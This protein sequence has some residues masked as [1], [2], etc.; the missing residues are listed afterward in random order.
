MNEQ[1]VSVIMPAYNSANFITEAIASVQ[2]Q[3]YKNW[4]LFVIDDF[5]TD[6]T[7]SIVENIIKLEPRVQL[8]KNLKNE[9]AGATRNKGITAAKG[10]FIA[11]LDAD[12]L[13]LPQKLE[14]QIKFM[15][16]DQLAMSFSSY[17][18]ISE[19][20]A[21]LSKSIVAP[22]KLSYKKLL[23]A[24][25]VG[26]LTGMYDVSKTGKIY[27]PLLRKRQDWALWL[28][29]LKK[30]K[31]GKGIQQP[32]ACY[33]IRK[34]GISTNKWAL[35]KYNYQIYNRFLDFG[36]LKSSGYMMLFLWEHFFVKTKQK[37]TIKT[38]GQSHEE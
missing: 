19:S 5:S 38:S 12:D 4:E 6:E 27:S 9:G 30:V 22:Q 17:H 11:F 26:N 36:I 25:Y 14:V 32:L 18:L 29:V 7:C 37:K 1:L 33:R 16:E 13:W 3:S 31:F 34:N 35:I 10:D 24:N 2:N 21:Y 15:A 28:S 8:L 23:K 20:G